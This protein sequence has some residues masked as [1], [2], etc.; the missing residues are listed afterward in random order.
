VEVFQA[1]FI[2]TR[3]VVLFLIEMAGLDDVIAFLCEKF[4]SGPE[5]RPIYGTG[6]GNNTYLVPWI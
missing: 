6:R 5:F 2:I 4:Y 1:N 3:E